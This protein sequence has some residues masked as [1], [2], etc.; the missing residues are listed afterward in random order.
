MSHLID[1]ICQTKMHKSAGVFIG[2]VDS[3]HSNQA[4][5][6]KAFSRKWEDFKQEELREQEKAFEFQKSWYLKLYGFQSEEQLSDYLSTK[7]VILDAGTGLG[8][9]AKWFSELSPN[10]TVIGIDFSNSVYLAAETYRDVPNLAFVKGDI[11]NTVFKDNSIDY[12]SCDQVI[13][14]TEDVAASYKEL[15]RILKPGNDLAVYVYAK[16]ALPRELLDEYFRSASKE[17]SHNELKNLSAQLTEL[18]KVLSELKVTL[19]VPEI[20]LLGIKGGETDI[21]RFIYWNF[22]KCFWNESLGH[23]TSVATNYDWYSPSNAFRYTQQ[24][25]LQFAKDNNLDTIYLHQE[26]ACHSGR[27]K[28]GMGKL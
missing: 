26:E 21:Q 13:H 23:A 17:L 15:S 14:H 22:I 20:P 11:A 25:F 3:N 28:K 12:V 8:Y 4:Q 2:A 19:N 1:A 27:F 16:K 7:P 18:G 5:T 6:N 9:K 24:E 10:S